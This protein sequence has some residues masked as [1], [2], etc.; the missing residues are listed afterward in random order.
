VT[1]TFERESPSP[2]ER[3][4]FVLMGRFSGRAEGS[5]EKFKRIISGAGEGGIYP[6]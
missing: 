4:V 6:Y 5:E 3:V 1:R 2:E